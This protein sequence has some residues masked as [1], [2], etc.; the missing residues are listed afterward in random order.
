MS[1]TKS[2]TLQEYEQQLSQII[3]KLPIERVTQVVDFA[4]FIEIQAEEELEEQETEE[5]IIAS[6]AK[7]DAL[8]ARPDA[9]AKL[10]EMA[11]EAL[12]EDEAGL[13]LEM[14]FDEEGNLIPPTQN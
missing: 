14:E 1:A 3:H 6:E 10:L 12:A 2:K 11:D 9:Q 4:R 7:W 5:E 13:T 8:L